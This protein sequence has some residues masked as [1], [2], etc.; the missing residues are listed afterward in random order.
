MKQN[1][2]IKAIACYLPEQVITNEDLAR[3]NPAWDMERVSAQSGVFSRHIAREDETA[4]DLAVGACEKLFSSGIVSKNEI[5]GIIFCTQSPDYVVPSNAFLLHEHFELSE[6]VIAFDYNLAC[7]GYI[8][9]L[10]IAQGFISLK[11]ARNILLINAD[12]YSKYIDPQDRT[13]RVLFGDGAAVSLI[14][15]AESDRGILDFAFG[16]SGKDFDKFYIPA[17][18][19]R[20]PILTP[21][22]SEGYDQRGR[23]S[24][25]SIRMDGRG[26][27]SFVNASVPPQILE[28]LSKHHLSVKDIDLFVFHQASKLTLDSLADILEIQPDKMF[29]NLE[30]IGNTVSASIPIALKAAMEQ[31][32]IVP[33]NKVLLSGFGAGF[34]IASAIIDF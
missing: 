7:S 9:G 33:G 6:K 31:E 15:Q 25:G 4:L 1:I 29:V 12:T 21:S 32:K 14:T 19:C 27:W 26:V 28:L 17:G 23:L 8:Y 3:E 16:T 2:Q 30:K 20:S 22:G 13:T 5:D 18:A 10:A 34:S 11:I 24:M